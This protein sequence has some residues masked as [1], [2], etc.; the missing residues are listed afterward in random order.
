MITSPLNLDAK[1]KEQNRYFDS[2]P[3][4]DLCLIGLFIALFNS[5]FIFA[6]GFNIELPQIISQELVGVPTTSVLTMRE[7]DMIIFEGQIFNI[8][9][10][11]KRLMS[12]SI[13]EERINPILL[14]KLDKNVKVQQLMKIL[15]IAR[16]YFSSVQLAADERK[17]EVDIFSKETN[18]NK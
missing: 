5:K 3:F 8:D 2:M 14:V 10:L 4:I 16:P 12:Y 11:Q 1:V 6:P 9:S 18:D 7:N 13:E 15:D 17:Q